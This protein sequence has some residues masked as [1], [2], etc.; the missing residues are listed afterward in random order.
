MQTLNIQ[1]WIENFHNIIKSKFF[2][3]RSRTR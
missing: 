3:P 1:G 2:E